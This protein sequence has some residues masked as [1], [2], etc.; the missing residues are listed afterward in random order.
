MQEWKK[1]IADRIVNLKLEP[2]REIEI[3][4]EL[5]Q[6]LADRYGELLS[7]GSTE[8]DACG[9][10][11]AELSQ[12]DLL[13]RELRRVERAVTQE[14]VVLG[15]R[16]MEM[17]GDLWQDLRYAMRML[18]KNP[19]FTAI[20]VLTLALGIG[21]NT[22]IFTMFNLWFRPLPVKDPDRVVSLA[23]LERGQSERNSFPY[24]DYA[25][26]RERAQVFS[27]LIASTWDWAMVLGSQNASEE[28]RKVFG[29]F[30]SDNFFSALGVNTVLGR[31]FTPDE[32]STPGQRPVVILSYDFWQGHFG[33]DSNILGRTLRLNGQSFVVVGVIERGF[34][35][36]T[37][38]PHALDIWLP[39]T[40]TTQVFPQN[41]DW[42]TTRGSKW[43]RVSGRLNPRRTLEDARAEMTVLFSQLARAYPEMDPNDRVRVL[44]GSMFGEIEWASMGIILTATTMVLLIACV[45]IVNLL[46]AR[47]VARRKE[48][49]I[50]LCLGAS[51]SRLVRQLLTESFLL[52]GLGGGAGLLL[53]WGSV[54]LLAVAMFSARGATNL[55]MIA[56]NLNPDVRVLTYTFLLS[57]LSAIAF[58]LAPALHASRADLAGA[59]KD[60]GASFGRRKARSRLRNWLVAA[61]VAVCLVLLIGAGLLLRGV[62]RAGTTDPGFET[63][64]VLRVDFELKTSGYSK[65]RGQQFHQELASRLESLP[66]VQSAS[67][68]LISPLSG[69]KQTIL[70]LPGEDMSATGRSWRAFYNAV[71]PNYFETI[72][73]PIVRGR[74]FTAEEMRDDAAVV[75]VT[76]STARNL[77]P[78]QE[79]LGQTLRAEPR[80]PFAQV[81]GVARDAQNVRLG[82]MDTFYLYVPLAPRHGWE[83]IVLVRTSGDARAM[84]SVVRAETKALDPA[85][86]IATG[87]LEDSISSSEYIGITRMASV[88]AAVL[89]LLALLL[90][91][92]G[93]YGVVSYGVSRQTHEIGI[94]MALG[95]QKTDVLKLVIGQGLTLTFIGMAIGSLIALA[96]MRL[97]KSL[98][99]G[100]S[101]ADPL[102]YIGVAG[103]LASVALLACY[104]PARRAMKVDPMVALRR[105]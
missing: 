4:D 94:R 77:W 31:V 42:F 72:G 96:L 73:I 95:A 104:L 70:T 28:T 79:P 64:N 53:A 50:R 55:G 3:V 90:A 15:A 22:A 89:G 10:V 19:G 43:V 80:A 65:T 105:E 71:T 30:V 17:I 23:W 38:G 35:G 99:F 52:A 51:R 1:E 37:F 26:L 2:T 34:G 84:Q 69:T 9:V 68:A 44:P 12:F 39:L 6:H 60:E 11:L 47:A 5:S 13:A 81:I 67:R 75:V 78:N 41:E 57:L 76:E 91:T 18:R 29:Q 54:K 83:P 25:Y 62:I 63:K 98:L 7:G 36:L 49:G 87:S 46:L 20:A 103:L 66:G 32:S 102:T 40:M 88:L 82:E 85:V 101:A 56:S 24:P 27:G 33:G 59:I 86:W 97:M 21:V 93:I 61:H 58:G 45:N 74:G 16:R 48:I 8:D 100:V 92:L 14:P